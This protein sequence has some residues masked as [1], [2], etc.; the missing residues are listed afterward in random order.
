M[1]MVI[2]MAMRMATDIRVMD[3]ATGMLMNKVMSVHSF[4]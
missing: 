2:Q 4:S 3:M 1:D